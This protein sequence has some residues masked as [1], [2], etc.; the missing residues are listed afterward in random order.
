VDE[1]A[2][3]DASVDAVAEVDELLETGYQER[4]LNQKVLEWR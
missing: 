1:I 3:A 4:L 2:V